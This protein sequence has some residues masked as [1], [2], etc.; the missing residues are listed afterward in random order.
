MV[1]VQYAKNKFLSR[2]TAIVAI[3][4]CQIVKPNLIVRLSRTITTLILRRGFQ[5]QTFLNESVPVTLQFITAF[6]YNAPCPLQGSL[7]RSAPSPT[8]FK[9]YRLI[10]T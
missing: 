4:P 6:L 10:K 5:V 3:G 2:E 7:L 1:C 9:Q 8:S